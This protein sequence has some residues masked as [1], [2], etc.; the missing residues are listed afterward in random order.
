MYK[1][2]IRI[3]FSKVAD[4]DPRRGHDQIGGRPHPCLCAAAVVSEGYTDFAFTTYQGV[5]CRLI[6][7]RDV[8]YGQ[9]ALDTL[10]WVSRAGDEI[11]LVVSLR[12]GGSFGGNCDVIVI[13]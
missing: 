10:E 13:I 7:R 6:I 3:G 4:Q 11:A 1:V 12:E 9:G 2:Q 5:P 8:G